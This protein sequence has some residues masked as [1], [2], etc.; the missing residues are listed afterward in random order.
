MFYPDIITL[1]GYDFKR[2]TLLEDDEIESI[3]ARL[4]GLVSWAND[5]KDYALQVAISD[6]K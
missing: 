6:K 1:Y 2:P 3:L 5:I 4:D